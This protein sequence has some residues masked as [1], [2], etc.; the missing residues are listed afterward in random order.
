MPQQDDRDPGPASS[1]APA[2]DQSRPQFPAA[3]PTQPM[4]GPPA[5]T[6]VQG[7]ASPSDAPQLPGAQ[8]PDGAPGAY[9]PPGWGAPQGYGPQGYGPQGYGAPQGYGPPQ[10]ASVSSESGDTATWG[11]PAGVAQTTGGTRKPTA[12]WK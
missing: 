10:P 1:G 12:T 4:A 3:N 7:E 6:P 2:D 11:A 5:S 8:H 9:P